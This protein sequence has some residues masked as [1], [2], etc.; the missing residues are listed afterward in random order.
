MFIWQDGK[1]LQG[2]QAQFW[3]MIGWYVFVGAGM[4]KASHTANADASVTFILISFA[5]DPVSSISDKHMSY[6]SSNG[7]DGVV[8]RAQDCTR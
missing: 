5:S 8:A 6:G 4:L 7:Q 3:P 2:L 1:T